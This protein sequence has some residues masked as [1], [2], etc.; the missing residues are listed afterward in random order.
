MRITLRRRR[1]PRFKPTTPRQ[2]L[3]IVLLAVGTTLTIGGTMLARH[4]EFLRAKFM[5]ADAEAGAPAEPP[6]CAAGQTQGC[7]GGTM[8][9]ILVPA[10]PAAASAPGR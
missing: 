6:R 1:G 2:R 3:L 10:A 8:G 4:V 9:V 7:V 5:R